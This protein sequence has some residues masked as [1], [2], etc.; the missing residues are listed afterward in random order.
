M[1]GIIIQG[2]ARSNGSSAKVAHYLQSKT[3]FKLVHLCELNIHQFD[4]DFQNQ[5]D[6][7]PALIQEIA[8][9]YNSIIFIT[10]VYWYC[11]SGHMKTFFDRISDCLIIK[12]EIGR[13]LRGKSNLAVSVGSDDRDFPYF[14][15]PFKESAKYLGMEYLGDA[16]VWLEDNEIPD[17]GKRKLDAL[18]NTIIIK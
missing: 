5:D 11:M 14:F 4:Y 8:N 1:S 18:C 12:K 3:Q 15:L 2:S 16:H 13:K 9:K 6:D 17:E 7:F 10:P